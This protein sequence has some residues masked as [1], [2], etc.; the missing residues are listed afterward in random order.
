[1]NLKK[2]KSEDT[3]R[4]LS[5]YLNKIEDCKNC[6][7]CQFCI[8]KYI[9]SSLRNKKL[10]TT[11]KK[12]VVREMPDFQNM[13][14]FGYTL[15]QIPLESLI[16]SYPI[17]NLNKVLKNIQKVEYLNEIE[18]DE[19]KESQDEEV[20]EV[21]EVEEET[22]TKQLGGELTIESE[23]NTES[24]DISFDDKN[25]KM[26]KIDPNYLTGKKGLER[27]MDFI[28]NKSPPNKGDFEYK[29]NT[30]NNYGNIFSYN[31]IGKYSSKIKCILDQIRI[32][33]SLDGSDGSEGSSVKVAD[34]VILIYSQYI[35]GGLIPMALALEEMGFTRY[36]ENAKQLFKNRPSEVVDVRTL[37]PPK[38]KKNFMPAR[39]V[40]ITGDPRLSPNNDFDVKGVT[41]DDNKDG[42][43]VKV[44]LISKAGS[45][46]IDFKFIRQVHILEPW[47][48]MNRIEQIIGR[49][50]RN[51]SHKDLPFEKRNVQI[52]M[53]GTILGENMEE[54][55]DLYVY[56][57]AEYKAIQI[58][59]VSRLLKETA[60]DCLI[61]HDQTNFTQEIMSTN[62]DDE[63]T[64]ELSNG[65]VINDFKIGDVPFSPAC[66]YM[67]TC[68]YSC[69]PT[70]K[71]DES[72]LNE[73]T[74]D[75]KFIVM[76]SEKIMQKIRM[77]M[78]E[79][80]FYQKETLVNLI[81]IPKKYPYIQIYAAL[82][83]LIE[84]NNEYI[85]DKYGRNGRLI[86]IGNYYLFQ[87]LEILDKN[88][89][90]YERSIPIDYKHDMI[91]FEL[92]QKEKQ[93]N[94]NNKIQ[95]ED[96][97]NDETKLNSKSNTK[98]NMKGMKILEEMKKNLDISRQFSIG[99]SKVPRGD[100][101]WF[102]HSGVVIRRM[103]N[104]YSDSKDYL[105]DFL[106]AHMIELLLFHEKLDLMNYIYSIPEFKNN[107][108][109]FMIKDYF[110]RKSI[111]IKSQ[112]YI[113]LY[114]LNVMK[115]MILND[116]NIW[117]ES[118]P[119]EQREFEKNPEVKSLLDFKISDYNKIVGFIG[120]E[121]NYK[122]LIFKTKD[123]LAKRDTGARC[124]ESGKN[125]SIEI[126][127]KIVGEEKYTKENTKILKD[128]KGKVIQ[129]ATGQIEL[130]IWQEF[131]LRYFDKI[132]KNNTK[133]F[134]TPEM[135]IYY[136]LYTIFIK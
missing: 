109:E 70:K 24:S 14:S 74:Y 66:D 131:I 72:D 84:D 94:H 8:Y 96:D 52:F 130:C 32:K 87:P 9:I 97:D 31:E 122:Y 132:K 128:E 62:L 108:V 110:E 25:N 44:I 86:N 90:I 47:Y 124:D 4:I 114:D 51:F 125:K 85:V 3:K 95:I 39:Y 133:W 99:N 61:N 68:N 15:L 76:N 56:R 21:E 10:S 119:E 43:K 91:R 116:N 37:K 88:I 71:I 65:L 100:D 27:M 58:G 113:I 50:V 42:N 17:E 5:L 35:D 23:E 135:A 18:N 7:S 101:N 1:M 80:F 63:I 115:I 98:S 6:G 81:Q 53:Y 78:R 49:A 13:E 103:I 82:T 55:A 104:E 41:S 134:L 118:E 30:L 121:K 112:N 19:K 93:R 73:D 29:R 12:G 117:I 45:E 129:E 123:M 136:K 126:L 107:S 40:M 89:S 111:L 38:D 46:G 20:E 105:L 54:A 127:N 59:K 77:L 22:S 79:S 92:K 57:V 69:I 83:T 11:T 60:V 28:D 33:N 120:Y 75:E 26:E 2:I 67:P 48:N 102:K 106:I 36:G 16:I 34:G 64:Q